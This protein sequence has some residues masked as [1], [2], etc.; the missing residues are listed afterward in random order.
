MWDF[1]TVLSQNSIAPNSTWKEKTILFSESPIYFD[2]EA[3]YDFFSRILMLTCLFAPLRSLP[4][5][6]TAMKGKSKSNK[7]SKNNTF[8]GYSEKS[9]EFER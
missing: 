1:S 8:N 4:L 6:F 2:I 7:K 9:F 3:K 5:V